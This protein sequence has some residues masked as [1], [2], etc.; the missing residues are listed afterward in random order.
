M[1][2]IYQSTNPKTKV[3]IAGPFNTFGL[4]KKHL[5]EIYNKLM[6]QGTVST[7]IN[8]ISFIGNIDGVDTTVFIKKD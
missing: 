5:L 8:N 2:R 1:Y 6:W 4:A 7:W 3:E